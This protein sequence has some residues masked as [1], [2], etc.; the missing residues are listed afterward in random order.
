MF[1]IDAVEK[2]PSPTLTDDAVVRSRSLLGATISKQGKE[3]EG[4]S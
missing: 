1:L 4:V 3:G 2:G